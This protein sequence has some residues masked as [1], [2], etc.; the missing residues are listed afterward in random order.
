MAVDVASMKGRVC[1]ITGASSGIGRE[2]ARALARMGATVVM[3]GRSVERGEAAM[4]Q[5]LRETPGAAV[6]FIPADFSSLEAVRSLVAGFAA[7]HSTLHV[8]INN[9]GTITAKRQLS[10]DG[11]EMQFAVNHL[12]HFLLTSLLLDT[13]KAS[14]PARI[15]NTSSGLHRR[16]GID[17]EDLQAERRYGFIRA[18]ARSKL[19]NVLFTYEFARRLTGSGVTANCFSPGMTRTDL[20]R[21]LSG[22]SGF[23]F[24]HMGKPAEEG[25]LTA[26]YLA[27]SPEVEGVTG[28]YFSDSK[29]AK[30]SDASHDS[31]TARRLWETSEKLTGLS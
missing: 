13:V 2:T 27:S 23:F 26:V 12:A 14:A 29:E 15:V 31:A 7:K 22:V 4:G 8:L 6:D 9:A 17:F 28:K 16:G 1:L 10:A 19:A 18:Y 24:R 30:S 3:T 21:D 5:I 25:A 11:Y 20:G